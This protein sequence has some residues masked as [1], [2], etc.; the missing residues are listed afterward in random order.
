MRIVA[1]LGGN[2]LLRRGESPEATVQLSHL[3]QAVRGLVPLLDDHEVLITH[4]N[5]PQVGLLAIESAS[6]PELA[7]PYP[8][9]VLDAQTQGMIGYWLIRELRRVRPKREVVALLTQ[10]IVRAD[11]PAFR[12]PS[13]FVGRLYPRQVPGWTMRPDGPGWRR[14]VPSPEPHDVVEL[15]V[16]R[17]LLESGCLVVAAGGVGIPILDG[18]DGPQGVEGVVDKDLTAALLA[19]RLGADALLLLTDVPAILRGYRTPAERAIRRATPSELRA[20]ALPAGSM[21]P[22]AEAACRF[23]ERRPDGFAAIGALEDAAELLRGRAGTC[24]RMA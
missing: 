3:E 6:D 12:Q 5:G 8:L 2:A 24:V 16:I 11:D 9:D 20:V 15:P 23:A 18:P 13:K 17:R 21:G 4:G 1:A 7:A 10:T 22:K 19:E 14:V